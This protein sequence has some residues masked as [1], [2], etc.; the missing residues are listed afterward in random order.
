MM[1]ASNERLTIFHLDD[2][3]GFRGGERQLL[4]L[5]SALRTAGHAN[6][7]CCRRGS[8]LEREA[9]ARGFEVLVLPFAFEFDPVSARRLVR[10]ARQRYRSVVHAHTGH[11]VGIAALCHFLGGPPAIAHR[12]GASR[13]RSGFSRWFKYD[14]VTRVVAV[15]RAVEEIL[16]CGGLPERHVTVVPDCVPVSREEWR[17]AGYDNPRFAPASPARR[18]SARRAL[19]DA[20]GIDPDASWVGNLAA[21]VPLKDHATLIAAAEVV[22]RRRPDTV[23][24]IGGEGPERERLRTDI[25]RRGLSERVILLGHYDAA[26]MFAAIDVFVLSSNREGMGS[27]LLEAA[28]CGVPVAATAVGGIPEVVQDGHT[29]LLV[30]PRDHEQLSVAITRLLDEPALANRLAATALQNVPH[31]GLAATV[32]RMEAIYGASVAPVQAELRVSR[33]VVSAIMNRPVARAWALVAAT[34]LIVAD[35]APLWTASSPAQ[36]SAIRE[37][38]TPLAPAA[39][40]PASRRLDRGTQSSETGMTFGGGFSDISE[41]DLLAILSATDSLESMPSA[42]PAE[43]TLNMP[44][45]PRVRRGRTTSGL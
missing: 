26:E 43:L 29:G 7:V 35:T 11:T 2:E 14:R 4:Y 9:R 27:V 30:E 12:R 24:L 8:A 6:V 25:E 34:L 13:L 18:A 39:K 28:L 37:S 44:G 42:A 33:R 23:F 3:R 15:S 17:A 16:R 40:R 5:A 21:L 19:A 41:R 22:L 36:R 1:L 10:A 31:F 45:R 20:Y 32:R 38:V